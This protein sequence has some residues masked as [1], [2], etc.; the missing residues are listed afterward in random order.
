MGGPARVKIFAWVMATSAAEPCA[1]QISA[2]SKVVTTIMARKFR[3]WRFTG[4]PPHRHR[5]AAVLVCLPVSFPRFSFP[6]AFFRP[7]FFL[8]PFCR[9]VSSRRLSFPLPAFSW[10]SRGGLSFPFRAPHGRPNLS[11][12]QNR[13][14][15]R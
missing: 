15:H 10:L 6:R 14:G 5:F 7:A 13:L 4:H 9:P 3:E 1:L 11:R 12:G 8:Q 2:P